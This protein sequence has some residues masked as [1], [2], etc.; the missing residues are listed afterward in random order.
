[1]LQ[2]ECLGVAAS[3]RC[4]Y[5]R[6]RAQRGSSHSH[7]ILIL[8]PSVTEQKGMT[9]GHPMAGYIIHMLPSKAR[10]STPAVSMGVG[11]R[12]RGQDPEASFP[13]TMPTVTPPPSGS[14]PASPRASMQ[15]SHAHR[16]SF[17]T[18]TSPKSGA[19]RNSSVT[20]NGCGAPTEGESCQMCGGGRCRTWGCRSI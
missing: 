12:W 1:M 20:T 4:D 3:D 11:W 6:Y 15:R 9:V 7:I 18:S 16:V 8:N 17:N 10:W 13:R 2:P 19:T 14:R 5:D